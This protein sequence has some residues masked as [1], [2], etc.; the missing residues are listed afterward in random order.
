MPG[1]VMIEHD[2]RSDDLRLRIPVHTVSGVMRAFGE[3][4]RQPDWPAVTQ[5]LDGYFVV[6]RFQFEAADR[7]TE[8]FGEFAL[9]GVSD[10]LSLPHECD[11]SSLALSA[12]SA[13]E[14]K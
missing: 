8:V 5:Y 4:P 9:H 2:V 11:K 14:M 7:L 12:K 6:A 10:R 13:D 3:R 1:E